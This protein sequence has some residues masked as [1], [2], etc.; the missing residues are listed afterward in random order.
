MSATATPAP[1]GNGAIHRT[2][3]RSVYIE[4]VLA[5]VAAVILLALVFVQLV[6][7]SKLRVTRLGAMRTKT[8]LDANYY[9]SAP[10]WREDTRRAIVA[11]SI[12]ALRHTIVNPPQYET[13]VIPTLVRRGKCARREARMM[14][15]NVRH[16]MPPQL[17][18]ASMRTIMTHMRA[19]L[20]PVDARAFLAIFES[21]L[22]GV[23][24]GDGT[25]GDV[26]SEEIAFMHRYFDG[27]LM[28][29]C[30]P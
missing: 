3:A 13:R 9:W 6:V 18:H 4:L 12:D 17:A 7:R 11:S 28:K 10:Q 21:V 8:R 22:L 20:D 2:E 27:V 14:L 25:E 30:R 5:L 19:M 1:P 15:E 26:T 24:T 23:H 29:A 16:V